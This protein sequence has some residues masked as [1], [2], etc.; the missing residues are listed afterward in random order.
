MKSEERP[1]QENGQAMDQY[2]ITNK[3]LRIRKGVEHQQYYLPIGPA[4]MLAWLLPGICTIR[5]F[6]RNDMLSDALGVF[7]GGPGGI[8]CVGFSNQRKIKS[9]LPGS[10]FAWSEHGHPREKR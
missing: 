5:T 2:P 6:T 3:E 1:C 4:G 10:S 8:S 9:V 7:V